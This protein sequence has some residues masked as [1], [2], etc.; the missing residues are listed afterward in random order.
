MSS[1]RVVIRA[2]A[3]AA[4]LEAMP[5]KKIGGIRRAFTVAED[6]DLLKYQPIR[7]WGQLVEAFGVSEN[8]LR[9]R[10]RELQA[11]KAPAK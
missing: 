7:T 10:W 1:K 9:R 3:I 11:R 4:A 5:A 6:T 2:D 8:T